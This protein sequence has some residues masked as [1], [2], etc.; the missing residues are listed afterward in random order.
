MTKRI[1]LL[2][3]RKDYLRKELIFNRLRLTTY[4]LGLLTLLILI[5][6]YFINSR[7]DGEYVRLLSAKEFILK[8]LIDKKNEEKKLI[9]FVEK[10]DFYNKTVK[11][12]INFQSYYYRIQESLLPAVSGDAS[13]SASI[14]NISLD[15]KRLFKSVIRVNT[16][17]ALFELLRHVEDSKLQNTFEDLALESFSIKINPTYYEI[18]L[19]GIIKES[20]K[21]I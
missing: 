14:V 5:G 3:K 20:E 18:V 10:S 17:T 13:S 6:L 1:N 15:N 9:T 19:T 4:M 7:T 12:D 16:D 2:L 11:S 8:Q 21:K